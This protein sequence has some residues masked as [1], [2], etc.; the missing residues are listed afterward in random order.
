MAYTTSSIPD[1][2][3]KVAVVTGANGGLGLEIAKGLAG[4]GAH[5]VMA[6]RN[7][8]KA[9]SA[10]AEILS[11]HPGASLEIVEL[12]LASLESVESAAATIASSHPAVDILANNA[13]VMALPETKTTDNFEMQFGVNHLGHWAFTARLMPNLLVAPAARVVAQ[14][15]A[16]RFLATGINV[17]NPHLEGGYGPWKAYGQSKLANYFFA[18]GLQQQFERAG[19]SA[20]SLVAHPGLTNSDL[21]ST[22]H[23]LGGAGFLGWFSDKWAKAGGMTTAQG[24]LPALRAATDPAAKGGELYGP[25]FTTFGAAVKRPTLRPDISKGIAQLWELSERETGITIDLNTSTTSLNQ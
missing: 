17:Q 20:I 3:G 6:A 5:V 9:R 8:T 11:T 22:T 25:C 16:A 12:D 15:S 4:A 10:K 18:L 14:S 13:G 2:S 21:Q 24:A 23:E 1:Q 7:Q 19:A